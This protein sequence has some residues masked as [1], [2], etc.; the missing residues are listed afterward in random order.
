MILDRRTDYFIKY[1]MKNSLELLMLDE[2]AGQTS[3]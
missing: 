3:L 2:Y 1:V